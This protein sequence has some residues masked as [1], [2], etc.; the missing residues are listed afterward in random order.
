[1]SFTLE[2]KQAKAY[3]FRA[4][5]S[6][7]LAKDAQ[8]LTIVYNKFKSNFPRPNP[9]SQLTFNLVFCHGTGFNKSVWTY[10][11]KQ[12]Y[13][14]SQ[15]HQVPWFLDTVLAIDAIG[16][17]DTSL[18]NEGKL[19]CVYMWDDGSKDVIEVVKHE[20]ATTGDM[21][22]DFESRNLI[23]GHS[24]GGF[25]ALYATFLEPALFDSVVAIEPVIYGTP[26]SEQRFMKLLKKLV[27]IMLDSF[28]TEQDARDYFEKY[29]FTKRF[30]SEVLQDY[31]ADE[32]YKTKNAEGKDV[33][34]TKCLKV[35]QLTTYLSPRMA[36]QKG[37]LILPL[38]RVPVFHVI[39]G[40]ANWNV[41][42][43]ITWIRTSIRSDML[44]G[45]IEIKDG[46]HLVNSEQPDDVVKIIRESMTKRDEEYKK[47][48]SMIPEIA[49]NGDKNAIRD[50]QYKLILN[51]DMDH[52]YG[53]D[54][55]NHV[56]FQLIDKK[57]KL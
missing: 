23:V 36:M 26:E 46:Q 18:A 11:I 31:I 35:S 51:L 8:D 38:I 16:H 27:G 42:E 17:G 15:S 41:R 32:I 21:K 30:Q 50:Q 19:G 37:M 24:M 20:L 43:S 4:K 56:P 52:V 22:N 48:R 33:Y 57:S 9:E 1:M 45:A 25:T 13:K 5:G 49:L 14:L 29:S 40:A 47:K 39:G 3:P 7:L 44:A 2:K 55:A 28:D 34:K 53:Y 54:A 10:L 12:L 6:T